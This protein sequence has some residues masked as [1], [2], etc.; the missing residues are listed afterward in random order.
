MPKRNK[1]TTENAVYPLDGMLIPFTLSHKCVKNFNLRVQGE[2]GFS[3]SVPLGVSRERAMRFIR[4][5]EDFLR[6]A[7]ARC[8]KTA[9]RPINHPLGEQDV[10]DG[11]VF[12]VLGREIVLRILVCQDIPDKHAGASLQAAVQ[13][14]GREI[15]Q[16]SVHELMEPT[17]R[18]HVVRE[19]IISEEIHRLR[20]ALAEMIPLAGE[21]IW[22]AESRLMISGEMIRRF[23]YAKYALSPEQLRLRDMKSRWGS[24]AVQTGVVTINSRLCFATKEQ[25]WYVVCHE[26]CH[27]FYPHHGREFHQLLDA[28]MPTARQVRK[29]LNA[30]DS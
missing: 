6:R 17:E 11:A 30:K 15:W 3:V 16:V 27:F 22:Q 25:L 18:E 21:R 10:Q 13:A 7:L 19:A 14:D 2:A 4:E 29:Q 5:H 24:C 28:V 26:L 23:P 20:Q 8:A 12:S 9:E 1:S